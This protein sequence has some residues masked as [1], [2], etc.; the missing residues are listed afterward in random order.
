MYMPSFDL[1]YE[2]ALKLLTEDT[3]DAITAVHDKVV[4]DPKA[5][6]QAKDTIVTRK[7]HPFYNQLKILAQGQRLLTVSAIKRVNKT[8][9]NMTDAASATWEEEADVVQ[10]FNPGSYHS[11][12]SIP[13]CILKKVS[14]YNGSFNIPLDPETRGKAR[15]SNEVYDDSYD[16]GKQPKGTRTKGGN[17]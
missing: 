11:P 4:I 15:G 6:E 5:L 13:L 3:T 14:D 16:K 9:A 7:G 1:I 10:Q 12:M 2:R 8:S 17:N